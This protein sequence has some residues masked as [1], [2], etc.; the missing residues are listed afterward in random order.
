MPKKERFLVLSPVVCPMDSLLPLKQLPDTSRLMWTSPRLFLLK[1]C[2]SIIEGIKAVN[3]IVSKVMVM[4]PWS[5]GLHIFPQTKSLRQRSKSRI[6]FRQMSR[7]HQK[8]SILNVHNLYPSLCS[9][10]EGLQPGVFTDISAGQ[11][12][13]YLNDCPCH[14]WKNQSWVPYGTETASLWCKRDSVLPLSCRRGRSIFQGNPISHNLDGP[15]ASGNDSRPTGS[16]IERSLSPIVEHLLADH[17]SNVYQPRIKGSVQESWVSRIESGGE[18]LT[19]ARANKKEESPMTLKRQPG[20]ISNNSSWVHFPQEIP[21]EDLI[22]VRFVNAFVP[23]IVCREL[24][25]CME[26]GV[27][28][29]GTDVSEARATRKTPGSLVCQSLLI[30]VPF[31]PGHPSPLTSAGHQ[32]LF[33]IKCFGISSCHERHCY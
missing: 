26:A 28:M 24:L 14:W 27:T 20:Q 16:P 12:G 21:Y 15:S 13:S 19:I 11:V 22:N 23:L 5:M 8:C 4:T 6:V 7:Y 33:R 1:R 17:A 9:P 32:D 10:C 25:P 3:S 29:R 2:E 18:K 31:L 30:R